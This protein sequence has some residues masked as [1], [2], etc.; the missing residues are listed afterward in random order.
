MH[1][2]LMLLL[3]AGGMWVLRTDAET[4]LMLFLKVGGLWVLLTEAMQCL[5]LMLLLQGSRMG[6]LRAL[7][8]VATLVWWTEV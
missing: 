5:A 2:L 3:Q 6:A 1:M 7:A 8:H 4:W